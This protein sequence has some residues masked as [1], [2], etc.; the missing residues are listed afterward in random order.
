MGIKKLSTFLE[1]KFTDC[2]ISKDLSEYKGKIV[3]IDVSLYLYKYMYYNGNF[4]ISFLNLI[5]RFTRNGI[6]PIFF[7]DGKPS[8]CK[9]YVLKKRKEKKVKASKK[10]NEI[11]FDKKISDIEKLIKCKSILKK[12]LEMYIKKEKKSKIDELTKLLE[13]NDEKKIINE[14]YT[15][16]N[17]CKNS[18]YSI[19]PKIIANLQQL[20][21][22]IGV[23]YINCNGEAEVI[24]AKMIEKGLLDICVTEDLDV[25]PNGGKILLRGFKHSLNTVKEFDLEK[26][27]TKLKFTREQFVDLCILFGCDYCS[28]IKGVGPKIAFKEINKHYSIDKFIENSSKKISESFVYKKARKIFLSKF[29]SETDIIGSINLEFKTT[30]SFDKL[31]GFINEKFDNTSKK[32]LYKIYE[33]FIEN[34]T[35]LVLL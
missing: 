4:Y 9:G 33:H 5:N 16:I 27:L 17:R 32:K 30:C 13:L 1:K 15:Q 21:D 3:G 23:P 24:C 26:I 8:D 35:S 34:K 31:F 18:S 6:K 19:T 14:V 29:N 10:L 2:V 28:T 7:F 12:Q 11:S 22:M 20:F 25:L